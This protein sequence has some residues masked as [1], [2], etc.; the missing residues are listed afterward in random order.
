M[1]DNTYNNFILLIINNTYVDLLIFNKPTHTR[2]ICIKDKWIEEH[3][4]LNLFRVIMNFVLINSH[5]KIIS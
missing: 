4:N 3:E 1:I 5:N 2:R